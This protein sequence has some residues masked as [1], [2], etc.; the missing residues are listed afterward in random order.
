MRKFIFITLALGLLCVGSSVTS[1]MEL[2]SS[3]IVEGKIDK[4]HACKSRG[5]KNHSIPLRV[6]S[7]PSGSKYLTIIMD[8]PDAQPVAGYTWV[9]WNVFN[10]L[11]DGDTKNI[12]GSLPN[13]VIENS[14]M[15]VQ[16]K[17]KKEYQGMCPPNGKH[18]YRIAAFAL[19][20]KVTASSK[21]LTIEKFSKEFS[22]KIKDKAI[23]TGSFTGWR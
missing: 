21:P 5:G 13:G 8:D 20:D 4:A 17:G 12:V 10:I 14:D 2:E 1:A 23:L 18:V 11:L 19:S 6:S 7:I 3:G 16:Q 9:H 15:G 22:D